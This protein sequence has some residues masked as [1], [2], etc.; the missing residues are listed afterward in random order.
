MLDAAKGWGARAALSEVWAKGGEGGEAVAREILAVLDEKKAA[1]KPLYD[2]AKPIKEKIETI[3]REIYG[4]GGVD[5][6]RGRGEEHRPVRGHGARPARRSASPRPSTPSPTIPTKLGRPTGFRLTIRD[7]YP[8]AGAGFVV[9]LAG[10]IMT[11]PGPA[12][13]ARRRGD[14]GPPRRHH[15][16]T[17]LMPIDFVSTPGAPQAIGPYSQG[18]PGQRLPLHRGPG[19]R[20]IPTTGEL[21]DGGIAE[22]T[23]RV[24][25]EPPGHPQRRRAAT[26]R[27]VVKTTVFLV[28][29]ADF[30][31]DERGLR[32]G[33]RR[34][35]AG[36][37]HRRGRRAAAGC[38]GRDRG[39]RRGER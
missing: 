10:D 4:A 22:Q 27:Q 14:P 3:A 36:A 32:P 7:V 9:A 38:P 19:R 24:L 28:D 20:S 31:A 11:M 21:V 15:R 26:S 34:P 35:P 33:L 13:G 6:T 18:D 2:V 17:L 30:A 29:M 39:D 5:Y 25:R 37:L 8:S 12:Q 16:G 1:F 23:E